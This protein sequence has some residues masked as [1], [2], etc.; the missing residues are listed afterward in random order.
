MRRVVEGRLRV[1]GS[2]VVEEEVPEDNRRID[3]EEDH[4]EEDSDLVGEVGNILPEGRLEERR[5]EDVRIPVE[6]REVV[7]EAD[8]QLEALQSSNVS[9]KSAI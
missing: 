4:R 9:I 3:Q 8:S 2:L 5:V 7:L 1:V 6:D